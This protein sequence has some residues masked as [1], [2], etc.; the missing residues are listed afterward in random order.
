[1][2]KS[3]RLF[4]V[5]LVIIFGITT[6]YY[7]SIAHAATLTGV[8]DVQTRAKKSV[9]SNH[10]IT[11]TTSSGVAAAGT[12]TI[13]F[14]SDFIGEEGID[15]TDVNMTDNGSE[16]TL[17]ATPSGTTWGAAFS[18]V[19]STRNKL[20]ITSDT[21]TIT[22][23]HTVVI[24]IGTNATGG[25]KQITNA[26]TAGSYS[27]S[28]VCGASDSGTIALAISDEDQVTITGTVDPYL[29]FEVVD[30]TVSLGTLSRSTVATDTSSMTAS[31][32]STLGYSITV[33]GPTLTNGSYTITPITADCPAASAPGTKQFGI[34][35]AAS[36]GS[37]APTADYTG[38]YCYKGVSSPSQVASSSGVSDTTTFTMT[39]MAN[40][41]A[42]TE[43]GAYSATHTYICTGNF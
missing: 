12:I 9:L 17:A 40:I 24:K 27:V 7:T 36:G 19:G 25:D 3:I 30:S 21:G 31:T 20:T 33:S 26:T 41:S 16:V 11:F 10:T 2:N 35:V 42:S 14:P 37:G 29:Q 34:K 32:N 18:S 15:Y 13:T 1:M 39:Y 23:G 6:I 4:G 5:I 28:V 43:A 22:A 38:N 8:S